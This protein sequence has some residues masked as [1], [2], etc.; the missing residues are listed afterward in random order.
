VKECKKE[1]QKVMTPD[2]LLAWKALARA[3]KR[4]REAQ[5][6][7]S[8]QG[9]QAALLKHAE[10]KS[11]PPVQDRQPVELESLL[12]EDA[13]QSELLKRGDKRQRKTAA[14]EKMKLCEKIQLLVS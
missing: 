3:A 11:L 2:E 4:L 9:E 6:R 8:G 7:A 10:R 14:R 13:R 12:A 5:E 1:Y